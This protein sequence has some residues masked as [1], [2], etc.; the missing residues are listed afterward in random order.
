[1][2]WFILQK[3]PSK[4][5]FNK[6]CSENI[7]Q[8][9]RRTPMPKRDFNKVAPLFGMGVLLQICCIFSEHL[10]LRK[11][12]GGCFWSYY[13]KLTNHEISAKRLFIRV[14]FLPR[15]LL[16][17]TSSIFPCYKNTFFSMFVLTL[18]VLIFW[19]INKVILSSGIQFFQDFNQ[20]IRKKCSHQWFTSFWKMFCRSPWQTLPRISILRNVPS[21]IQIF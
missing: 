14:S 4:G 11:P 17:Y 2:S 16:N 5:V 1:M 6:M 15:Q 21:P 10:F 3:Q 12:L 20:R 18:C 19:F 13:I 9:Y 8:I 7:Q